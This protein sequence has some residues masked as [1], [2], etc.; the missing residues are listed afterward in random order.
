VDCEVRWRDDTLLSAQEGDAA[1]MALVA[2]MFSL[3]YGHPQRQ[4]DP[5]AAQQ[6]Y[7]RASAVL[8]YDVQAAHEAA[9]AARHAGS[10]ST[11]APAAALE[12]R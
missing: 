10:S 1:A 7:R 11:G 6:W 8:G 4:A 3:G 5:Q 2:S 12:Q 9:E